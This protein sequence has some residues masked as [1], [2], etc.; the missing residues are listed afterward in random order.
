MQHSF[1]NSLELE[2]KGAKPGIIYLPIKVMDVDEDEDIVAG[3]AVIDH[4]WDVPSFNFKDPQWA[5]D[6][7]AVAK[8][9]P[10]FGTTIKLTEAF[11]S[12]VLGQVSTTTIL[13]QLFIGARCR[14]GR[15]PHHQT[16]CTRYP[17]G[18]RLKRTGG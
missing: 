4:K 5:K 17:F 13:A 15:R 6:F 14:C 1:A 10:G 2:F 11:L 8:K 7:M 9:I 16:N 3:P 12:A 18:W